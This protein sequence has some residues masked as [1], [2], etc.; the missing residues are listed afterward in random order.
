V[1]VGTDGSYRTVIDSFSSELLIELPSS[2]LGPYSCDQVEGAL[3]GDLPGILCED[4]DDGCACT[5]TVT[6]DPTTNTG[7]WSLTDTN[8]T[9]TRDDGSDP[10]TDPYCADVDELWVQITGSDGNVFSL[11]LT[12]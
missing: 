11:L 12:K 8:I 9:F 3:D 4:A 6:Q 7:T 10:E 2:C 1:S 5:A